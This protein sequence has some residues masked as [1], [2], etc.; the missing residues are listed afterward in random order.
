MLRKRLLLATLL[1][2]FVVIAGCSKTAT[3]SGM[4]NDEVV[5]EGP[6]EITFFLNSMGQKEFDE[7]VVPIAQKKFPNY[8][9]KGIV[10]GTGTGMRDL[11]AANAVPDIVVGSKGAIPALTEFETFGDIDDM[12]KK[13]NYDVSRLE[14]ALVNIM[15]S[16]FQD[17][18]IGLP[19]W[20]TVYALRYNKDLFDKFGVAYPKDGMT[21]DEL[22]ELDKKLTRVEGGV[23]Y[24]G[25]SERWQNV[26]LENNQLSLPIL[27]PKEEKSALL[28]EDFKKL[29][30]SILR[31]YQLPGLTFDLKTSDPEEDKLLFE[32]GLS[33][34]QINNNSDQVNFNWD[35]VTVPTYKE[36][37]GV[38]FQAN[39]TY[40]L[41]TKQSKHRNE[42]FQLIAYLTSDEVQK[43]L[44]M[45][46][47]A[48]VVKEPSI[49]KLFM[50]NN[51]LYKGKRVE[52]YFMLKQYAPEPPARSP[53]L[54]QGYSNA[55]SQ[56]VKKE[57]QNVIIGAKDIN[58]ALR[59]A[60][61]AIIKDINTRKV[62]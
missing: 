29:A 37:P 31:F 41:L 40:L 18:I 5:S 12:I 2:I 45:K 21:W 56:I 62:K 16:N 39:A 54:L 20:S 9:L 1:C 15:K 46:G 10:P 4:K 8:T 35:L 28:T 43:E 19:I 6:V 33:A 52:A 47:K 32:K 22:Y 61:E 36:K 44:S 7:I 25:F 48:P 60:D 58:T 51:P 53:E 11:I 13:H 23:Q 17:K 49:Q 3:D 24:R 26:L 38:N 59:D 34:M 55:A 50:S 27:D 57:F 42:A 30:E 14:P